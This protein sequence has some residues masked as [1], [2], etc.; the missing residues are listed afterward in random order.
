MSALIREYFRTLFIL[1]TGLL[2]L[3]MFFSSLSNKSITGFITNTTGEVAAIKQ[4]STVT[5]SQIYFSVPETI[6]LEPSEDLLDYVSATLVNENDLINYV[7]F[8]DKYQKLDYIHSSDGSY[9]NTGVKIKENIKIV[10]DF[11][12]NNLVDGT[13]LFSAGDSYGAFIKEDDDCYIYA[14][15]TSEPCEPELIELTEGRHTYSQTLDA[16]GSALTYELDDNYMVDIQHFDNNDNDI[17]LFDINNTANFK[18]YSCQI[19]DD[20]ELI[21]NFIPMVDK[22]DNTV[23]LFDTVNQKTYSNSGS[24][25]FVAGETEQ[26]KIVD[27]NLTFEN[28]HLTKTALVK[29]AE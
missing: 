14:L 27:F 18:L 15:A 3:G 8:T 5:S 29:E 4:D 9:I 7:K 17:V 10:I 2:G 1:L 24:G 6:E 28:S 16:L 23:I 13:S 25:Q 12:I 26:E 22:N 20:D 21:R 11:E 19:Y